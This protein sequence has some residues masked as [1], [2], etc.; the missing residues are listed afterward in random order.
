MG[1]SMQN[2]VFTPSL[3]TLL[4]TPHPA[5]YHYLCL[6]PHTDPDPDPDQIRVSYRPIEKEPAERLLTY[7]ASRNTSYSLGGPGGRSSLAQLLQGAL[8]APMAAVG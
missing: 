7:R 6:V 3:A 8:G 2:P 4:R 5:G 1:T